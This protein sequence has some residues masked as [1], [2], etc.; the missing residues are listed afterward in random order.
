MAQVG[1]AG[2]GSGLPEGGKARRVYLL[3]QE[4]ILRGVHAPGAALEG[5]Q[6][7]ALRLGVSRVTVR[8]ALDALSQDGMIARRAGSG[9]VVQAQTS[10]P[11]V[12][13][14]FTTLIPQLVEMDQKTTARLLS[15]S[16]GVA[17][18]VVAEAMGLPG[19]GR[20]QTAVRV[21][22]AQGRAFSHLTT[23]VPE[24]VAA[25][26]TEADLATTP[27]F[28]LLERSGVC[29]ERAHQ[30]VSATLATPDVAEVLGLSVGA[31]VLSL[32]RVVLDADG[33]GVEY[34]SA[35][36][37]PDLFR[38]EMSLNR[39]GTDDTRHWEPVIDVPRSEAAE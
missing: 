33:K 37:R 29:I 11:P 35:L 19:D 39:V 21:R 4:E 15:F 31:P 28:R 26:Y 1:A 13:A 12:L 6:K 7:L 10:Y 36:Y 25:N 17:P 16:Y 23:Y 20:V 24:D 27:L 2:K 14:D 8:R 38:L 30:S 22:L 5:E 3:L 32:R 9:T 34:L 18:S